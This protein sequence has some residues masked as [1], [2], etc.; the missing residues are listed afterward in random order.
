VIFSNEVSD[1]HRPNDWPC[2][3]MNRMS[4]CALGTLAL[5]LLCQ[6]PMLETGES[7]SSGRGCSRFEQF[8][9]IH[10]FLRTTSS[11]A[12]RQTRITNRQ[13]RAGISGCRA[14]LQ[15]WPYLNEWLF[16]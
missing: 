8:T 16:R 10:Q 11:F 4:D 3:S 1:A 9:S 6:F 14:G 5:G 12:N 2:V 7:H 15:Q 13:D